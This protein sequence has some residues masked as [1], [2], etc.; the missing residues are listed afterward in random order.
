MGL[1]IWSE[2]SSAGEPED[3]V[4]SWQQGTR[5]PRNLFLAFEVADPIYDKPLH[6][7]AQNICGSVFSNT[8]WTKKG[9]ILPSLFSSHIFSL[10]CPQ[11]FSV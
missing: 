10:F 8:V 1:R 2:R 9:K 4:Q 3:D 7:K 5:R 11:I 6:G